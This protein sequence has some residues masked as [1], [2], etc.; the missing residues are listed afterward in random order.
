MNT[1]DFASVFIQKPVGPSEASLPVQGKES[2]PSDA[3]LPFKQVMA[4][5]MTND[6]TPADGTAKNE[7]VMDAVFTKNEEM[8]NAADEIECYSLQEL[9]SLLRVDE[10]AGQASMDDNPLFNLEPDGEADGGLAEERIAFGQMNVE[11][12]DESPSIDE[13]LLAELHAIIDAI[14]QM[15]Q[16]P[17]QIRNAEQLTKDIARLLKTWETLPQEQRF[18]LTENKFLLP[19]NVKNEAAAVLNELLGAYE[20]RLSLL[21]QQVYAFEASVTQNDLKNWLTQALERHAGLFEHMDRPNVNSQQPLPMSKTEQYIF[22]A[23]KLERIDAISR[24]LVHDVQQVVKRSNFLK[25]PGLEQL[26][27][28]LRPA[29]LGE[30][31]IRLVQTD[32]TMTVKFIVTTQAAKEL[33]EANIHQL[34]HM[35]PPNQIAIERDMNVSDKQFFQ[36]EQETLEQQ[37]EREEQQE[38]QNNKKQDENSDVS[39]EELL[40]L[41]SKEAIVDA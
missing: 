19:A 16:Q 33:F 39:F 3:A 21:K 28:T 31:T 1:I 10:A 11:V 40:H 35:F 15:L 20:N 25:Q 5:Q 24:N 37:D 22:H 7:I 4:Q 38:R 34:K 14:Q 13:T 36:E 30:V 26:T 41:L 23:T 6:G 17:A 32:G 8:P 29:S 9:E 27:F 18:Y 12:T 2:K